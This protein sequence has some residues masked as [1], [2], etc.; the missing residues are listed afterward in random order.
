MNEIEQTFFGT[1]DQLTDYCFNA[2]V[3][4]IITEDGFITLYL[5][6]PLA[7]G[8]HYN[9]GIELIH[10]DRPPTPEE[11]NVLPAH[12]DRLVKST[13]MG[14]ITVQEIGGKTVWRYCTENPDC[15]KYIVHLANRIKQAGLGS[16][17][18]I[19]T[20]DGQIVRETA[21]TPTE[22]T[23]QQAPNIYYVSGDLVY[24]DKISGDKVQRDKTIVVRNISDSSNIAI[25]T[26]ASANK[27]TGSQEKA[28]DTAVPTSEDCIDKR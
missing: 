18:I 28:D 8:N 27:E 12:V 26:G 1:R 15:V 13:N 7:T 11:K 21:V 24:G 2:K 4:N 17:P 23:P 6:A 19:T 25:G 3:P 22:N 16:D 9:L 14:E 5:A 20:E 10:E